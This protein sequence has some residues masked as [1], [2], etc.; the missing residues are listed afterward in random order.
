MFVLDKPLKRAMQKAQ[1]AGYKGMAGIEPE[2]I[3][4]K[5]D[6]NGRASQSY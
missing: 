3:A 6:E 4:M 1:D 2:F 5:Y